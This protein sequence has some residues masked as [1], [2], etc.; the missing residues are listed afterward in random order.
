MSST[1]IQVDDLAKTYPDGTQ[2]VKGI[3]FAVEEGEFFGFLGP[4]GAGKSTTIKMLITLLA[5]TGGRALI[6]GHDVTRDA[7][8][9]RR[10]IGYAAQEVGVDNELTGRE[11]LELQ[12]RLYHLD[13]PALKARVAELLEL[14]DLAGDADRPAGSYSGGM[15]KRLDLA[16]GLIHRPE[17]LFLDE[18]TTGLDPQ[19]RAG[20]WGYLERLNR[21]EGLTILLT[22]H[23]LEEADRLCHRVAIIDHGQ[24]IVN[25]T[26]AAL[27]ASVGGDLISLAFTDNGT[28]ASDQIEKATRVIEGVGHVSSIAQ[29]DGKLVLTAEKGGH[30]LTHVLR[31]L[32]EAGVYPDDLSLTTPSLDDVFIKY[33]GERIRQDAPVQNWRNRRGFGPRRGGPPG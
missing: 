20:L 15:R 27:K 24:I 30:A 21:Q 8:T 18:P 13:R 17:V 28:S 14:V 10:L 22:T 3:S 19:N 7:G 16:T 32:D 5:P 26:P 25:D 33:T 23:Y 6:L 4:N 29:R 9:V 2:A 31:A 12:G 11:N 1:M